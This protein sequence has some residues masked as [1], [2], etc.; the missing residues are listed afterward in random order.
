M[1]L[2]IKLLMDFW[3]FLVRGIRDAFGKW[4]DAS[5]TNVC[6]RATWLQRER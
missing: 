1:L 4:S 3:M 5:G 6:L 2:V